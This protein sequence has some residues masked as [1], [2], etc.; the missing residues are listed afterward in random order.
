MSLIHILESWAE[1]LL[2]IA[3][4]VG[5]TW[6]G[7]VEGGGS[8]L[9]LAVV[10]VVFVGAGILEIWFVEAAALRLREK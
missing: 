1:G 4:G 9:F 6:I 2:R 5:L 3:I 10:G 7:A 8:G